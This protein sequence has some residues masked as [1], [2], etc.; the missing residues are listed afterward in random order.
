MRAGPK[1]K[2]KWGRLQLKAQLSKADTSST[3]AE[4]RQDAGNFVIM[5]VQLMKPYFYFVNSPML[6]FP[7]LYVSYYCQMKKS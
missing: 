7:I 4:Q 6:L 5:R 2:R 3:F 1:Q